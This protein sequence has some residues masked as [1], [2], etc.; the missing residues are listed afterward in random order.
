MTA[1]KLLNLVVLNRSGEVNTSL[2]CTPHW[3][4]RFLSIS[5]RNFLQK[6]CI[7]YYCSANTTRMFWEN[8]CLK[9]AIYFN[10][11][12]FSS[13][14]RSI[15]YQGQHLCCPHLQQDLRWGNSTR[16]I[17]AKIICYSEVQNSKYFYTQDKQSTERSRD[18]NSSGVTLS[19]SSLC[20]V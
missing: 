13:T 1:R 5:R 17:L 4:F 12:N 2:N 6:S 3:D 16:Y 10:M 15:Y 8:P 19:K 14:S 9:A 11:G 7:H 20:G 18:S